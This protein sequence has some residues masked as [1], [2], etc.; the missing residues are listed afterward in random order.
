MPVTITVYEPAMDEL[1]V[2]LDVPEVPRETVVGLHVAVSPDGL[3]EVVRLT[4]PV[5]P[6]KLVTVIVVLADEPT[7]KL[8]LVR[9]DETVK[10]AGTVTLKVTVAE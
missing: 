3:T 5:K 6:F 4:L 7:V 8:T 10:S 1:R 9:S 2:Q